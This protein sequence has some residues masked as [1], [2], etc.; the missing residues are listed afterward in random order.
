LDEWIDGTCGITTTAKI[1][2]RG[3]LLP[4]LEQL[5][6]EIEI[7][8]AVPKDQRGVDD[9]SPEALMEQWETLAKQWS[10]S[11][12]TVHI[13]DRTDERRRHLRDTLVKDLK[14]DLEKVD[15]QDTVI[16]HQIADAIIKVEHG[17]KVKDLRPDG[18]PPKKLMAIR[19]RLGDAGFVT[20]RDAFYRVISEAPTVTAPLSRRNSLGRGG[21][22]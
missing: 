18:F 11:A 4:E 13:Q 21:I 20:V 19:D 14:L 6:D 9:R 1:H 3:D 7:A 17:G 2:Q 8:K 22:T 10:E 15:D 12:L 5:R 16:M